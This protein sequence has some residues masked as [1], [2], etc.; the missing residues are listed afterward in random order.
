[1]LLASTTEA[2]VGENSDARN[3][4]KVLAS[5]TQK[6]SDTAMLPSDNHTDSKKICFFCGLRYHNRASCPAKNAICH[7]CN[8]KGHFFKVCRSTLRCTT[9]SSVCVI[10]SAPQ[11]LVYATETVVIANYNLSVLID[12]GSSASYINKTTV[13]KLGLKVQPSHT[14]VSMASSNLKK[15]DFWTMYR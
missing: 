9:A 11:C 15:K 5:T 6:K 2:E 8:K 3:S 7:K 10:E 4:C 1:M 13:E 14:E 12:T